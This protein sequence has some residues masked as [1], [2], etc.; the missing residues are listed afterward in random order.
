MVAQAIAAL[1]GQ[2]IGTSL[3]P[4]L[5]G[6]VAL[7]V[8]KGK[9]MRQLALWAVAGAA[10]VVALRLAIVGVNPQTGAMIAATV[11]A[12]ALWS[13]MGFGIR[14]LFVSMR[15]PRSAPRSIKALLNRSVGKTG[16]APIA[17]PDAIA[18]GLSSRVE[19]AP[20]MEGRD[21]VQMPR[22]RLVDLL[23][24]A[25]STGIESSRSHFADIDSMRNVPDARI[26]RG[27]FRLWVALSAL[28]CVWVVSAVVVT[29]VRYGWQ[30]T[31]FTEAI[32]ALVVP[33]IVALVGA[34][35]LTRVALWV[36]N[37]FRGGP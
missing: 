36:W 13:L 11:V 19:T 10:L 4:E 33:P 34:I 7:A 20:I 37:G 32:G 28:W 14:R 30:H 22:A 2:I 1:A 8:V 18:R 23:A 17:E 5:W 29:G 31:K 27:F 9:T 15:Q 12:V 6:G 25:A 3:S 35:V 24:A 26:R 21:M 16:P